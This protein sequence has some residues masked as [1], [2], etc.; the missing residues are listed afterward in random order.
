M[1][2]TPHDSKPAAGT[3]A[4]DGSASGNGCTPDPAPQ[5]KAP[6]P[7]GTCQPPADPPA[8]P[9]PPEPS[10]DCKPPD[11][12]P[13]DPPGSK[14]C[15]DDLIAAQQEEIAKADSAKAFKTELEGLLQKS[16]AAKADYTAAKYQLLLER[17][18]AE[19]KDIVD[20]IA[21]LVCTM[22]CW[23]KQ[24]ECFVCPLLYQI[25]LDWERLN[26]K[27]W[28]YDKVYSLY[29]LQYWQQRNVAARQE[30]FSRVGA[31][32]A[33]WEKPAATIDGVLSDN[34]KLL[35]A[36]RKGLGAPDAG[37]LI[38]DL[39][40]RVIPLHLLIAPPSTT[41]VTGIDKKYVDLCKC[42][43]GKPDDCC[44]PDT[45]VP[46][47]LKQWLGPQPYLIDPSQ[48]DA[49]ICCLVQTRYLPAKNALAAAQASKQ[50]IDNLITSTK[51]GITDQKKNLETNAKAKLALPFDCCK[52]PCDDG[53][54]G[55]NGGGGGDGGCAPAPAPAPGPAPAPAP[56]PAPPPVPTAA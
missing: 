18:K 37:K 2:Q 21:K 5:P 16:K 42:D 29:D 47:V 26:G 9:V 27:V 45:G 11:C 36:I 31:V 22:P 30:D 54:G 35:D 15:L 32:L 33:A 10:V 24:I 50:S 23:R 49:L 17:W 53:G 12:C 20:L 43:T 7:P 4:Q 1:N 25:R 41:A 51:A 34:A 19:D 52:E 28:L 3:P 48:Y 13:K 8:A 38:W 40:M 55:G 46:S 44:G 14:T 56:T 6:P 39:F